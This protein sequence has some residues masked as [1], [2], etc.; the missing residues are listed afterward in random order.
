MKKRCEGNEYRDVMGCDVVLEGVKRPLPD[1]LILYS[2]LFPHSTPLLSPISVLSFHSIYNS[3]FS[4]S[5]PLCLFCSPL[6]STCLH[7]PFSC[8]IPSTLPA[9]HC[10]KVIIV[11]KCVL[12]QSLLSCLLR[13]CISVF[14]CLLTFVSHVQA[15]FFISL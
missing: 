12:L 2:S 8:L 11:L 4:Q 1:T 13:M 7:P 9:I 3:L 15:T 14:H 5:T 10:H 6:L